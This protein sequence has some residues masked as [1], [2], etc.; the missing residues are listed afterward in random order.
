MTFV[1]QGIYELRSGSAE[2]AI[3]YLNNAISLDP[4]DEMPYIV[5]SQCL[6]RLGFNLAR[7]TTTILLIRLERAKEAIS[8]ADKALEINKHSTKAILAKGEALYSIGEFE[9]ALVQFERGWRFRQDPAIK[10]GMVKCRDAIMITVG[11]TAKEYD[12]KI[13]EMVIQQMKEGKLDLNDDEDPKVARKQKRKAAAEKKVSDKKL[14][15]RLNDDVVFLEKFLK[16]QTTESKRQVKSPSLQTEV[17][18]TA[19]EATEATE[20]LQYLEKRKNFW[21]QTVMTTK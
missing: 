19:T 6:N 8:D 17:K 12:E 9:K 10:S 7:L 3:E 11:T 18:N 15:G 4:D 1:T 5:R 20:A 14:L 16:T 13:V 21:Q 2:V